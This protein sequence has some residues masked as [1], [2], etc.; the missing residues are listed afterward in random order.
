MGDHLLIDSGS[1]DH[2]HIEDGELEK[3]F[4]KQMWPTHLLSIRSQCAGGGGGIA[5]EHRRGECAGGGGG[6]AAEQ[7]RGECA[8]VSLTMEVGVHWFDLGLLLQYLF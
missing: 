7:L 2:G 3:Y 4:K 1:G 8:G 5:A 6:L